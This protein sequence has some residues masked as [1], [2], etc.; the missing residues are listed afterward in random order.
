MKNRN[1]IFGIIGIV[2]IAIISG[3]TIYFLNKPSNFNAQ[4]DFTLEPKILESLNEFNQKLDEYYI[5]TWD[6]N[7]FISYYS[8]LA[9]NDYTEVMLED[10]EKS[11]NYNA[12]EE[13]KKVEIHFVKPKSLKPYLGNKIIDDDLEILTVYSALPVEGGMYISSKYDK[14]GFISSE[15]YKKFVSE[16]SWLKGEMRMPDKDS[17]E[18]KKIL[19]AINKKDKNLKDGNIKHLACNDK[20]AIIVISSKQNPAYIKQYALEKQKNGNYKV[21]IDELE[22]RDDKIFV[23]YAY[24]DFDLAL[25]PLYQI[26]EYSNIQSDQTY[27][28]DLLKENERINSNEELTYSCGAGN[29]VYLEFK[30]GLKILLYAN[31]NNTTDVYEVEDFTVALSKMLELEDNPPAFILNFE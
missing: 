12:P 21:I 10:V 18:Y 1:I 16:H 9:T 28:V 11:L 31:E 14:G 13:I 19:K 20:Y 26:Y 7:K 23:N 22:L 29:F 8:Y 6:N 25:L 5:K 3:F 2:I 27:L 4:S 30:S 15:N 24:T 17:Q